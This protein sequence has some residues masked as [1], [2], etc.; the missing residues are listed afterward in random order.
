[1]PG[2]STLH[3]LGNTA[4]WH[5]PYVQSATPVL[6]A[7]RLCAETTATED[8]PICGE[9]T[10]HVFDTN[11]DGVLVSRCEGCGLKLQV[12]VYVPEGEAT[13]ALEEV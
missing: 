9:G 12:P 2:F 10:V 6:L 4:P 8:C 1:M 11:G 13:V 3:D 5:E 7:R